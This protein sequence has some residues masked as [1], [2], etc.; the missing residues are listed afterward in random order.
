MKHLQAIIDDY[1]L[2]TQNQHKH[3]ILPLP[4]YSPELNP[5]EPSWAT[6][7]RWL[8]SYLPKFETIEEGLECYFEVC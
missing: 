2:D 7:K 5:I 8:R 6:I 1:C 4:P 3:I